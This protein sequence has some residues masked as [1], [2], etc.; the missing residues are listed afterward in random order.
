MTSISRDEFSKI[1]KEKFEP[2]LV[3]LEQERQTFAPKRK[4]LSKL[5]GKEKW[6]SKLF[7][8]MGVFFIIIWVSGFLG[9]KF[10][11]SLFMV[12]VVLFFVFFAL[13]PIF[14]FSMGIGIFVE[15]KDESIRQNLKNKVLDEIIGFFGNFSRVEENSSYGK[16]LLNDVKAYGMFINSNWLKDSDVFIGTYK[17]T[18]LIIDECV[19]SPSTAST[20]TNYSTKN[21]PVDFSGLI[22]KIQMN[23]SFNGIT[24]AGYK[25]FVTQACGMQPVELED[26]EFMKNMKVYSSDQVEAR[27]LLTTAFMQRLKELEN[28]FGYESYIGKNISNANNLGKSDLRKNYKPYPVYVLFNKGYVYLFI[29]SPFDLFEVSLEETLLKEDKYFLMY[30]QFMA[31]LSVVDYLKLDKK[32]GL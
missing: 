14:M 21:I 11:S 30:Q 23:K 5:S 13:A 18:K 19:F 7:F 31:I 27:Y 22:V 17:D 6:Y 2:V 4:V 9:L 15:A 32:L 8:C 16:Q 25:D 3:K 12:Y 1:Y 24:V 20:S 26:V 28:A 10:A 29:S